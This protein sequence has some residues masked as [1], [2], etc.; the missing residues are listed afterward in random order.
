[1]VLQDFFFLNHV[2]NPR[3]KGKSTSMD[4]EIVQGNFMT[5]QDTIIY[6]MI[7]T[8]PIIQRLMKIL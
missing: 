1:M 4:V 3:S 2:I 8:T 6:Y 5:Q 7:M